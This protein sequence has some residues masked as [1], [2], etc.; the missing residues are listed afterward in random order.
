M[1]NNGWGACAACHPFGLSDDVVWIFPT[2]PKRTIPQHTDFDQTDPNRQTIRTLNWSAERDE[3]EDFELNIRAVS[4]GQGLIV[5]ADGVTQNP[6]VAN[7][8]PR[9]SGNRNQ[10]KVHEVNAARNG[11]AA[12]CV[13]LHRLLPPMS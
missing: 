10:L 13:S 5:L 4:G 1:S 2:G 12:G 7:L 8:L 6:N 11:R 9:A 3:E